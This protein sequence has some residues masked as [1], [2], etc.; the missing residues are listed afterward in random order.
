MVKGV[1]DFVR[2]FCG[3]DRTFLVKFLGVCMRFGRFRGVLRFSRGLFFCDYGGGMT[4][5][6][7]HGR[8]EKWKDSFS[9]K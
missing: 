1:R 4:I 6:M 2:G 3:G 9:G 8:P 7:G 5:S